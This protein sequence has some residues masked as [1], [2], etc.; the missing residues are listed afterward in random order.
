M[1][2][3]I[4]VSVSFIGEGMEK[5]MIRIYDVPQENPIAIMEFKRRLE[6]FLDDETRQT[7]EG[8]TKPAMSD[9]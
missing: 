2:K 9:L 8:W 1:V 3:T 7:D 6:F 4:K 5:T